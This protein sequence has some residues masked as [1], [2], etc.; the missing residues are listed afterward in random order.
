[1]SLDEIHGGATL[2]SQRALETFT[3]CGAPS[4]QPSEVEGFQLGPE[5]CVVVLGLVGSW[6]G[7]VAFRFDPGAVRVTGEAMAGEPVDD[8]DLEVEALLEAVNV[9][10]GRGAAA[11][12]ERD[13]GAVWLTPPLYAKGEGMGVRLMNL[14]GS[15]FSYSLG[16]GQGGVLFSA[17][18]VQGSTR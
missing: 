18:P 17:A 6:R 8:P 5:D 16:S 12:A 13:G 10:A 3:E 9:V 14:S 11:L 2:F 1:M 15:C 4:G 7:A